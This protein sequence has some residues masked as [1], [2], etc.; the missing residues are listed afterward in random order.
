MSKGVEKVIKEN[1]L[2]YHLAEDGCYYPDLK[3]EQRTDYL[4]GKYGI[5]RAE[6]M[7]E[8]QRHRYL[9]MAMEGSWNEYLHEVDE[10]CRREVELAVER[11][12][13]KEGITEEMKKNNPMEWVRKMN[14]IKERVEEIMVL[15][16]MCFHDDEI[17]E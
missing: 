14:G 6:Y 11:I 9:K 2:V 8:H 13:E 10:E 3:M 17:K 12:K 4:I 7:M 16:I 5:M 15:D 1:G